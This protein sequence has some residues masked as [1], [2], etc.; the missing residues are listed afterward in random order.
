[1]AR[2]GITNQPD[3]GTLAGTHAMYFC[4]MARSIWG[5]M[6]YFCAGIG[7]IKRNVAAGLLEAD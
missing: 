2:L 5:L 3:V 7:P 6:K 1:M 4:S